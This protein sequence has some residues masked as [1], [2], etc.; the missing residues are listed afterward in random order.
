MSSFDKYI[1]PIYK[2]IETLSNFSDLIP[3]NNLEKEEFPY[4]KSSEDLFIEKYLLL[5]KRLKETEED[6]EK[7]IQIVESETGD[8]K[9]AAVGVY[10]KLLK[11]AHLF[12]D[13]IN[14]ELDIVN[15]PY[16]GKIMIRRDKNRYL[17]EGITN[18]YIGKFSYFDE[19]T[20]KLLITDWRA[21]ITNV[22]YENAGPKNEIRFK[23]PRGLMTGDLLQKRQFEISNARI[24]HIY[25][26]KSGNVTAD[27]FLLSQLTHR[28]G[29]KLTD[30]VATIQNQ[31]N[32][33]I[34]SGI[35]KALI[36]Q[37]VAGSGKTTI[38]LHRLAYL[39]YTFPKD[40]RPEKCLIMAPNRMFLDYISDVLPSLGIQNV[41]SNTYIFWAKKI[42]KWGIN[43]TLSTKP[44]DYEIKKIKSGSDTI[45]KFKMFFKDFELQLLEDLP[46]SN[47]DIVTK[48]Y[49][50]LK[51]DNPE[52][53]LLE[54]LELAIE[55]SFI[56]GRLNGLLSN[57]DLIQ[58][59]LVGE[60]IDIYLK[61]E[62]E[63]KNIYLKFLA[64]EKYNNKNVS[65]YTKD[66][67]KRKEFAQ[68]DLAVLVYIHFLLNGNSNF[69][70]DYIVI[71]E[72]QDMSPFEIFTLSLCA[73]KGN[74]FLAGDIAQSI[75]PPFHIKSWNQIEEVLTEFSN[76]EEVVRFNLNRCYRTTIE[77]IEYANN[78]LKK[79]FP[80]EYKLPEAVLRHGEKVSEKRLKNIN[81]LIKLIN[82]QFDKNA[83]SV[84][85][86]TKDENSANVIYEKLKKQ[87]K[88]LT[89]PVISYSDSDY[90]TG[91]LVL[92]ITK[93]KGLEFDSV[94]IVNPK[95]YNL[96]VE[97]DVRQFYVASTRALH[98]LYMIELNEE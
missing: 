98:R 42:L 28:L 94:L 33:I 89:Q 93:A 59:D 50:E 11:Q 20:N 83:V 10:N 18:V 6:I 35:N 77:I 80:K 41:E 73:R 85:L 30:I 1:N 56:T 16:F 37:G 92:P 57:K 55:G 97:L 44:V 84:A 46:Y 19:N 45:A 4:F 31:Q 72:A 3:T 27:E 53:S 78:I 39:F 23:T 49:F 2:N 12:V 13:R 15:S 38:V 58:K 63:I 67:L 71:D 26:A 68:E 47:S 21:P 81:E 7:Q 75:V 14:R 43:Y 48:K 51:K 88:K 79:Y 66:R 52:I 34:R 9:S 60:K 95:L 90:R 91:I 24:H 32:E 69:I 36:L 29:K 17:S 86:I 64:D 22:Y 87:Q 70:K 5:K 62:T 74:L 61:K 25:D 8:D 65:N 76:I 96:E 40:V 54:R 82:E